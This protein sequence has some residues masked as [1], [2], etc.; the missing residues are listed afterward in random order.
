M[1][2]HQN[3]IWHLFATLA[4][5]H[6]VLQQALDYPFNLDSFKIMSHAIDGST[7]FAAFTNY[8]ILALVADERLIYQSDAN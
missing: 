3:I 6:G 5:H 7:L 8:M 4:L 1:H 2:I